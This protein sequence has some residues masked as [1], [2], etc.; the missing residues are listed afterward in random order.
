MEHEVDLQKEYRITAI[1]AGAMIAALLIYT[2]IV[3]VTKYRHSPFTGFSPDTLSPV[4][5]IFLLAVLVVFVAIR[6]VRSSILKKEKTD[7][8][9]TLIKKLKV[10]TI[11]TFAFCEI[12]AILGLVVFF[13]GGR[14]NE[15]Y[16]LL[17][18]SM[19]I[20]FVYF[21]RIR[22]WQAFMGRISSFY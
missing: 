22:H 14:D 15:Y 18:C 6:K 13:L 17:V 19:V 20:M 3:E 16:I 1:I 9:K 21:P 10:S 5:D 11:V 2:A 12:P 7:N 8:R 4:K